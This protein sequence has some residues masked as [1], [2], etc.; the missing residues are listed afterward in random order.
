V[1]FFKRNPFKGE[2][3]NYADKVDDG[4]TTGQS[5]GEAHGMAD[6][7]IKILNAALATLLFAVNKQPQL[8]TALS[9]CSAHMTTDKPGTAADKY[10][11]D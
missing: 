2:F 3:P 7:T 9:Q 10:F 4:L 8:V 6:I 5:L 1:Q 11:H